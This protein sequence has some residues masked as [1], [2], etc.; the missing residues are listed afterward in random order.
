MVEPTD[1]SLAF[2]QKASPNQWRFVYELRRDAIKLKADQRSSK[3]GGPEEFIKLDTWF[4]EKLPQMIHSR[5]DPHVLYEELVQIAKWRLMMGKYR[6]KMLDL[7]RINTET[8]VVNITRKAFKKLQH[9]KN[10][11]QAITQLVNLK[12][13]GPSTAS[14]VLAAA[15]PEEAPFMS[16]EGMLSTPGV[17]ATDSTIAEFNN[18]SEQLRNKTE[19]LRQSDPDYK[20]TPHKVDQVLWI[21]YLIKDYKPTLLDSMPRGDDTTSTINTD[22]VSQ[23][24]DAADDNANVMAPTTTTMIDADGDE[25]SSQ[26]VL[27]S[28]HLNESSL[29]GSL[30]DSESASVPYSEEDLSSQGAA[31]CSVDSTAATIGS[32]VSAVCTMPSSLG[33]P[34]SIMITTSTPTPIIIGSQTMANGVNG[35]GN[36]NGAAVI[37]SNNNQTTTSN[38]HHLIMAVSL[39]PNMNINQQPRMLTPSEENSV[40]NSVGDDEVS[41]DEAPPMKKQKTGL[42]LVAAAEPTGAE[43]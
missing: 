1:S 39:T 11:Q 30:E 21:Y 3:K 33:S 27:L 12:G 16:D 7:V 42:D 17:E 36:A 8:S 4:R 38:T 37:N 15:Y 29:N 40:D 9:Q 5:K 28:H 20:W 13:I 22:N 2:F 14:A 41:L 32:D 43:A 34:P 10:L 18:Y 19:S 24:S 6:P 35:N 31:S 25:S 26:D 23:L